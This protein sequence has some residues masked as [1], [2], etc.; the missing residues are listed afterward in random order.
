MKVKE[1]E[2]VVSPRADGTRLDIYLASSGVGITRNQIAKLIKEGKITVNDLK[3]KPGYRVRKGDIVHGY[4]EIPEPVKPFPQNIELDIVYEDNDLIVIN[5]DKGI[6]VHPAKGHLEGTLVNALIYHCKDLPMD[7]NGIRPGVVHRLDMNTTG[8]IVFAK[9]KE[10]AASLSEQIFKREVKREYRAIVWGKMELREGEI[11][12]PL[13]RNFF[14]RKKVAVTAL[15]SREAITHYEVVKDY[16]VTTLIKCTLKTG[17]T[18]QIRVHM[19]HIGH[20]IVGDPDYKG[21]HIHHI[22]NKKYTSDFYKIL[23]L[24]DRQALHAA[25]LG[26]KH[27][28]TEKYMEFNSPLPEDMEKVLKYLERIEKK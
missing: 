21:R 13:G 8:L 5:K 18:H 22:K 4:I 17:R 6:V 9:T 24:I 20:P 25:V 26:F 14:D 28:K 11:V 10:A 2:R 27:P 23:E 15:N 3:K 1:F 12:A 7:E 16:G 19:L